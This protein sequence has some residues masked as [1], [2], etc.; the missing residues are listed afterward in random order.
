MLIS[1]G[2]GGIAKGRSKGTVNRE[3]G[4]GM[5]AAAVVKAFPFRGAVGPSELASVRWTAAGGPEEV[6]PPA[7][8]TV[9]EIS[10]KRT[11]S[12]VSP[13]GC[14]L[15]LWGRLL[16]AAAAIPIASSLSPINQNFTSP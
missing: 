6:G 5:A 2:V 8:S 14:H 10:S 3:Q 13:S 15:P 11:T 12:S 1:R 9:C 7:V 4:T 16:D